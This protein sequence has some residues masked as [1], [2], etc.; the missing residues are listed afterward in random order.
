MLAIR[1]ARTFSDDDRHFLEGAARV[2]A[3]SAR[4]E[5]AAAHQRA[6]EAQVRHAQ[7]ME[8]IGVLAGG[9]AHDFNNLLMAILG[10]ASLGLA[11][12]AERPPPAAST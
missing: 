8:S 11:E 4:R 10:H 3:E 2:L 12:V 9:I 1:A 7:K 5:R 6:L